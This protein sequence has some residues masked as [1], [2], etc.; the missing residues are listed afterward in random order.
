MNQQNAVIFDLDG[1]LC[2]DSL[3][4]PLLNEGGWDRYY[5]NVKNDPPI[6]ETASFARSL[7]REGFRLIFVT[8]R[9][10]ALR[11]ESE[12]WLRS[13]IIGPF[14]ELTLLMRRNDEFSL[15]EVKLKEGFI[16]KIRSE[17][18]IKLAIDCRKDV[19]DAYQR[20]GVSAWL[21]EEKTYPTDTLETV[22]EGKE[23]VATLEE[24]PR[25]VWQIRAKADYAGFQKFGLLWTRIR[26][27][28]LTHFNKVRATANYV[29]ITHDGERY[30]CSKGLLAYKTY[31]PSEKEYKRIPSGDC[32][33]T[34]NADDDPLTPPT[35]GY[36][37]LFSDAWEPVAGKYRAVDL[38]SRIC[39]A[40]FYDGAW[41]PPV[42]RFK[43]RMSSVVERYVPTDFFP[44]LPHL[45]ND[46]VRADREEIERLKSS[47]GT[48]N[49]TRTVRDGLLR[50]L[51]CCDSEL[52]FT[53]KAFR[54]EIRDENE[55]L[56][57]PPMPIKQSQHWLRE[58]TRL[59]CIEHRLRDSTIV[60]EMFPKA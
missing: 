49:I 59:G 17:Y 20:N 44:R 48:M 43:A 55:N 25:P 51:D 9:P 16:R 57:H 7:M 29:V 23:V 3:R 32:R 22:P 1:T 35:D 60:R 52:K 34:H 18:R 12:Y 14:D 11:H 53:H 27:E 26:A 28:L 15:N 39:T 33:L 10:E 30:L 24:M 5:E 58:M 4:R 50:A 42:S 54:D 19:I 31:Y 13:H 46:A 45:N 47:L 40:G 37:W 8:A 6:P 41:T 2:D 36:Y 21:T 38:R 56:L